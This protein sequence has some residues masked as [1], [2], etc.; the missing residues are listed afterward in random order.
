MKRKRISWGVFCMVFSVLLTA[1][2]FKTGKTETEKETEIEQDS[3]AEINNTVDQ[4]LPQGNVQNNSVSD[5]SQSQTDA[6]GHYANRST[7]FEE[8]CDYDA[9]ILLCYNASLEYVRAVKNQD[10][11]DFS[12]YIQNEKLIRYMQYQ[13]ENSPIRYEENSSYKFMVTGV[14]FHDAYAYVRADTGSICHREFIGGVEEDAF[15]MEG[16]IYF[17]IKNIEGR[18][19]IAD[20]YWDMLD[21]P[22]V[23]YRGEYSQNNNLD[24]WEGDAKTKQLF[25]NLG[26][27]EQ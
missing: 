19:Y 9:V 11:A 21:S 4:K 26:L 22:D 24:Y 13:T 20:W 15:S 27:I 5:E 8:I 14:E 10:A 6:N 1:C 3:S 23:E 25:E 7:G 16:T 2:S 17:L 12:P 18:L